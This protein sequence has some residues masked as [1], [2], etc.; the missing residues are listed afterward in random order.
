MERLDICQVSDNVLTDVFLEIIMV[1]HPLQNVL[2]HD[3][4]IINKL[5][6][7]HP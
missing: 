7:A 3:L 1:P 6:I 2:L 4:Q 5:G